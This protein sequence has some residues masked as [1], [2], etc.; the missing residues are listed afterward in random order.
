MYKTVRAATKQVSLVVTLGFLLSSFISSLLAQDPTGLQDLKPSGFDLFSPEF[1]PLFPPAMLPW[2]QKDEQLQRG[3]VEGEALRKKLLALDATGV[4]YTQ[5]I[6][7]TIAEFQQG[8]QASLADRKPIIEFSMTSTRLKAQLEG[9]EDIS[10]DSFT[11]FDGRWFGRWGN[12][13]VNHDWRPSKVFAEPRRDQSGTLQLQALQYA[14]IGN[15]FGWN[16]LVTPAQATPGQG[17]FPYVLGM[18]Y[19]FDGQDFETIRGE[20]AHVGF[21]DSPN[22]LVWITEYEVFLEEVFPAADPKDTVYAI[23]ALYH[24]LLT[25]KPTVAE[26]ATQAVYTRSPQNRPAFFEYRWR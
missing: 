18:V 2:S 7:E 3:L 8:S 4:P 23:T 5:R 21:A 13:D 20:K 10:A 26:T 12:G 22:R 19:Y 9:R 16:Y 24:H 17:K 6:C 11:A 1:D 25:D 14:W 15:G